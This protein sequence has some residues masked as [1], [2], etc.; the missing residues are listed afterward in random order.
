MSCPW[1]GGVQ[2]EILLE[3]LQQ[4]LVLSGLCSSTVPPPI[5]LYKGCNM[6]TNEE[7]KD[8]SAFITVM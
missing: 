3:S 2:H 1:R 7:L 6:K 4:K 5:V 8:S